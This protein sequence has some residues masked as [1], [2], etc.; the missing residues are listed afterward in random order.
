MKVVEISV[1]VPPTG[2]TLLSTAHTDKVPASATVWWHPSLS[3]DHQQ[4]LWKAE[5]E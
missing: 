5:S 3:L 4:W 2:I 1:V